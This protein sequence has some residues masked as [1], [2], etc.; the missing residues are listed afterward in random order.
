MSFF[1][2]RSLQ[3][4]QLLS[5]KLNFKHHTFATLLDLK[6]FNSKLSN[7]MKNGLVDEAQ[8]L[9]GEMPHRSTVTYNAMI[10]GYF[11]NGFYEKAVRLYNQMPSR[12]AFSYN[13]M[14][15]GLM[16][17]GDVEGAEDVFEKMECRDVVTWNSLISGYVDNDLVGDAVRVFDT[18]PLKDVV[19]WNLVIAGLVK[20]RE[21][22]KAEELFREMVTRDVATWTIMMKA[23]LD[24]GRIVESREIFDDMPVK[25]IQAWNTIIGGYIQNNF[26][27]IAE[28]LFHK[29]PEKDSNSWS[30]MIDVF[31]STERIIDALRLFNEAP[32]KL[33]KS[34]NSIILGFVKNGLVREAHAILEKSPFGCVVS[35]TN[36]MIGYFNMEDVKNAMQVFELMATRDTTVWNAAIF[37]LGEN[38]LAEDGVKLAIEMKKDGLALDEATFTSFLT[39]CS[40][41]PSLNLGK[42]IHAEAIKVGIDGFTAFGNALITMY[43]RC[44]NMDS[45]LLEFN[46]MARHDIISWNSIICGLAHHGHGEKAIEMFEKMRLSSVKPNQIT[47]VGV[48]SA[49]SHGGLVAHGK[50]FFDVMRKEYSIRLTN[51]HYT[52][53]VDLLGKFGLI[54]EAMSVMNRMSVDGVEIEASVWGALLGACRVHKNLPGAEIAGEKILELEPFNSG[55]YLILAE[56]YLAHGRRENAYS[57]WVRMKEKGVKKQPGCSWIESN[58]G[59]GKVFLAGDKTHPEFKSISCALDL[60][61]LEMESRNTKLSVSFSDE[62]IEGVY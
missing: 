17:H 22:D 25:D 49:C 42:Q 6:P 29:M 47:F 34:W 35:W 60:I 45:A 57:M 51:E 53:M 18:M 54:D 55:V 19:S 28:G 24:A 16:Q 15:S 8:N 1:L 44:G 61:Y 32:C 21:F 27:E 20:V 58:V 48:L 36:I 13:T 46:I 26:V 43:F 11:Q 31:V 7:L 59:G 12:D 37:G 3:L 5:P 52:C 41:L 4:T 40:N 39:I 33:Q 2:R 10:R 62:Y 56:I 9:F 38:D 50:H 30:L 23:F 14:I